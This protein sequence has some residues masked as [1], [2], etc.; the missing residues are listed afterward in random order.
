MI[1]ACLFKSIT[2]LESSTGPKETISTT[3]DIKDFCEQT[4]IKIELLIRWV[5]FTT[6][7]INKLKAYDQ[8]AAV[9]TILTIYEH[10]A[11][12]A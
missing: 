11:R 5:F 6:A 4:L 8:I 3:Y 1:R 2:Y 12:S 7:L 10:I 9:Q